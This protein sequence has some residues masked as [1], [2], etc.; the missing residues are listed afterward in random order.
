MHQRLSAT[1]ALLARHV[2]K[3]FL[4]GPLGLPVT[5]R[6]RDLAQR[7]TFTPH[8]GSRLWLALGALPISGSARKGL[9]RI[10]YNAPF[11]PGDAASPVRVF[12][13]HRDLLHR[14]QQPA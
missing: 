6:H 8:K 13:R 12:G 5:M 1:I 3:E 14:L 2:R 11:G 4:R 7:L 9:F 10:L